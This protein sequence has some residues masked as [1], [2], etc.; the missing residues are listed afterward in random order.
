MGMTKQ[1]ALRKVR[2]A[3]GATAFVAFHNK[4]VVGV[5]RTAMFDRQQWLRAKWEAEPRG[6]RDRS[7]FYAEWKKLRD[8]LLTRRCEMGYG[9]Q[10]PFGMI[11]HIEG[12]GDTWEE[13]FAKAG[14]EIASKP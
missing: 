9:R 6:S 8:E 7:E 2:K 3:W 1:Q 13:A 5:E 14:V 10:S 12:H 4:A 11:Y